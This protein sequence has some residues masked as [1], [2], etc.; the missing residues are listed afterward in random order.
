ML[1]PQ[2]C[3]EAKC[4]ITYQ[5]DENDRYANSEAT[6]YNFLTFENVQILITFIWSSLSL[7]KIINSNHVNHKLI[8]CMIELMLS[9]YKIKGL[10]EVK[11]I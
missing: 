1:F 2:R 7:Q 4:L 10:T 3:V 5:S 8:N 11:S 6:L 9:I